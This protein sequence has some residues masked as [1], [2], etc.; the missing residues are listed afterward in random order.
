LRAS[1]ERLQKKLCNF[2]SQQASEKKQAWIPGQKTWPPPW[3][4]ALLLLE[5]GAPPGDA[6][7]E[8]L[9]AEMSS[10]ALEAGADGAWPKTGL[11]NLCVRHKD[12][13]EWWVKNRNVLLAAPSATVQ[14]GLA[15]FGS[16][17]GYNNLVVIGEGTSVHTVTVAGK[18]SLLAVGDRCN[19]Y[20][21]RIALIGHSTVLIGEQTTSTF[22]AM[23]DSRNG[24][25]I[26]VGADNMWAN[27]VNIA[28]DDDHA[29]R[30]VETGARLNVFGGRVI[31]EPHV[32][33]CGDVRVMGNSRIG[34]NSVIGQ[35][36]F[37]KSELPPDSVCVG[38]P[39]KPVRRGITWTR[40]DAP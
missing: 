4:D 13:P 32:W 11:S 3:F 34:A 8:A 36:S 9:H 23:M 28:T 16:E 12:V 35:G 18:G 17:L 38:R 30:D 22:L 25:A 20:G 27:G 21:A 40:E 6:V 1:L 37:V 26:L 39:A 10:R 31:I 2:R 33:L 19:L 15:M 14:I 24:G 7:M 5:E 29:I